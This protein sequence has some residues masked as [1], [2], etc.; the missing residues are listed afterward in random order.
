MLILRLRH[1][2]VIVY[3][4]EYFYGGGINIATPGMTPYGTPVQTIEFVPF[5]FFPWASFGFEG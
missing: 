3:N 2:G 1:T 5:L 4:Q